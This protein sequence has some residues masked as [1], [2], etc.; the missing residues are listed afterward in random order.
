MIIVR[1]EGG[2]KIKKTQNSPKTKQQKQK[3]KQKI[4]T[5]NNSTWHANQEI[6][7]SS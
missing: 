2:M 3:N 1:W 7:S 5:K 4:K 6:R